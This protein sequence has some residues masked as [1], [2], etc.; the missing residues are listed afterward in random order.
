MY[1]IAAYR[2]QLRLFFISSLSTVSCVWSYNAFTVSSAFPHE[3]VWS[4]QRGIWE[5]DTV[6]GG[7]TESCLI[8]F[9]SVSLGFPSSHPCQAPLIPAGFRS[10]LCHSIHLT[11][12]HPRVFLFSVEICVWG[13]NWNLCIRL[14]SPCPHSPKSHPPPPP[15]THTFWPQKSGEKWTR[16]PLPRVPLFCAAALRPCFGVSPLSGLGIHIFQPL[17]QHWRQQPTPIP[18][19]S[20]LVIVLLTTHLNV[21]HSCA[22][23]TKFAEDVAAKGHAYRN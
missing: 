4:E 8:V 2:L 14:P 1:L 21:Y 13:K 3:S 23:L 20:L 7:E 9:P 16:R 5:T 22:H 17:H 19:F 12:S 10:I 18:C 11:W 6:C 15:H